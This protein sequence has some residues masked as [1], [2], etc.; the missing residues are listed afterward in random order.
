MPTQSYTLKKSTNRLSDSSLARNA[1]SALISVARW[2][3]KS[4]VCSFDRCFSTPAIFCGDILRV[5]FMM[6]IVLWVWRCLSLVDVLGTSQNVYFRSR[7]LALLENNLT[8]HCF[9]P[10]S[11]IFSMKAFWNF[12]GEHHET[13]QSEEY[14]FCSR[15]F[16]KAVFYYI[17]TGWKEK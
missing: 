3:F 1:H 17:L 4:L 9:D 16:S 10:A 15:F 8:K 6:A 13:S 11:V 2:H 7:D 5:F 12:L 14:I